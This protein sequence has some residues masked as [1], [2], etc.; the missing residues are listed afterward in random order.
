VT[1][2]G[3]TMIE[4]ASRRSTRFFSDGG[5]CDRYERI[6]DH[7]VQFGE[8]AAYIADASGG[9]DLRAF[10]RRFLF[11]VKNG[12]F[13]WHGH[14]RTIERLIDLDSRQKFPRGQYSL[15][16][17]YVTVKAHPE[18]M[19]ARRS[20]WAEWLQVQDLPIPPELRASILI[21]QRSSNDRIEMSSDRPAVRLPAEI[22]SR[23]RGR[24]P[25]KGAEILARM[26]AMPVGELKGMKQET[27]ETKF[28]AARSTC[29]RY[30]EQVLAEN[31]D[32]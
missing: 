18:L 21:E 11:S 31:V 15:R 1:S 22:T 16:P 8:I 12:G 14:R 29:Q 24:I 10:T 3:E 17:S 7:L 20:T 25:Q 6:G 19:R 28:G 5:L 26:R 13:G 30:R 23:K 32:K 9:I 4:I 2:T 27:M